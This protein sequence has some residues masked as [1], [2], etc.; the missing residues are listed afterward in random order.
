MEEPAKEDTT[1]MAQMIG[2]G[3]RSLSHERTGIREQNNAEE[4]AGEQ[5]DRKGLGSYGVLVEE[6]SQVRIW[7]WR[8]EVP[9][10]A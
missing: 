4:E 6:I 10:G 9:F 3:Q 2:L 8:R 7:R 1:H 5:G